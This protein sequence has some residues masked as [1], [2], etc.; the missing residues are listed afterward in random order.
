MK[1]LRGRLTLSTLLATLTP[2]LIAGFLLDRRV[3]LQLA[4]SLDAA[5]A[6]KAENLLALTEQEGDEVLIEFAE[7]Y[8]PHLTSRE[9]VEVRTA[10]GK[11]LAHS[12]ALGG[13]HLGL[14]GLTELTP[15]YRDVTLPDGRPGRQIQVD[16]LPLVEGDHERVL[17]LVAAP[18]ELARDP[19]RRLVSALVA[20]D[21]GENLARIHRFR[22]EL[23]LISLLLLTGLALLVPWL[24][25]R[26]LRP[27]VELGEKVQ[28]LEATS[29]EQPLALA[30][31]PRELLPL[32]ARLDDLR[33]RLGR[34]FQRE[35]R[36]SSNVAHE[37]RTP[38]AELRSLAEVALR[39][40]PD[41]ER[42]ADFYRDVLKTTLRMERLAEQLLAL[43]RLEESSAVPRLTPIPL[44]PALLAILTRRGAGESCQLEVPA[45][46]EV[47]SSATLLE[48]LLDNLIGNALEHRTPNT[49]VK[50][51]AQPTADGWRLTCANQTSELAA[52]DLDH[53]FDR[54]WRKDGA[55]SGGDGHSGL[56]LALVRS[57]A[58]ALGIGIE[59]SLAGGVLE[60]ALRLSAPR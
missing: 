30:G 32:I 40:P 37:L 16:F 48:L 22:L 12:R 29:L 42:S 59:T 20:V 39:F 24:V 11:I 44:R 27:L 43:A 2:I 26:G 35:R 8:L 28:R 6:A 21:R 18:A 7:V 4:A 54:F 3:E 50:I 15:R 13:A 5:L 38:I 14:D 55:R 49:P 47:L 60:I 56:G 1:S 10:D 25:A 9:L 58:T 36:F 34:S 31:P 46:A 52:A 19:S 45:E 23:F 57:V 53:L 41:A 17:A 33:A 51:A